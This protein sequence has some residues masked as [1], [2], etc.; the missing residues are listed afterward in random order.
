MAASIQNSTCVRKKSRRSAAA[1]VEPSRRS[2]MDAMPG[3]P[4]ASYFASGPTPQ[5]WAKSSCGRR[6]SHLPSEE[7]CRS[8]RGTTSTARS[9]KRAMSP[10]ATGTPYA[11]RIRAQSHSFSTLVVRSMPEGGTPR[12]SLKMWVVGVAPVGRIHRPPDHRKAVFSCA[13][14]I[15]MRKSSSSP[16]RPS[17]VTRS[18]ACSTCT[19]VSGTPSIRSKPSGNSPSGRMA[20]APTQSRPISASRS[21]ALVERAWKRACS[22]SRMRRLS[23]SRFSKKLRTTSPLY[24]AAGRSGIDS[25]TGRPRSLCSHPSS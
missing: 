4:S 17:T 24:A 21:W 5:T 18:S 19:S 12:G 15:E 20:R 16:C 2:R 22:R 11:A 3:P 1:C 8:K 6:S 13:P 14:A 7:G 9:P 10:S 25:E 23:G